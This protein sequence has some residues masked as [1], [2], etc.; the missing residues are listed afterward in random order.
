M[1]E[2]R[3]AAAAPDDGELQRMLGAVEAKLLL[4]LD[5]DKR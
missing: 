4:L 1:G 2:C 3:V 5:K